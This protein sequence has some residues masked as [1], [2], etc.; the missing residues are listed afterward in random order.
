MTTLFEN[1]DSLCYIYSS[2]SFKICGLIH[3][4]VACNKF[5]N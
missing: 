3:K 2:V 5:K 1:V 4:T